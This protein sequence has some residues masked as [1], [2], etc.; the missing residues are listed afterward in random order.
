MRPSKLIAVLA[1]LGL[2]PAS[3]AAAYAGSGT[4]Y[5]HS[6]I[7]VVFALVFAVGLIATFAL[8]PV[9]REWVD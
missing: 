4:F 3:I 5:G 1:F 9:L 7:P 8:I 6:A 2:V